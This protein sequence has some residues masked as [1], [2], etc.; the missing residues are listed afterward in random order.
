MGSRW[1]EIQNYPENQKGFTIGGH[2]DAELKNCSLTIS[3]PKGTIATVANSTI[4]MELSG[5]ETI[6]SKMVI[7]PG[8]H[9]RLAG[10]S[11]DDPFI[12]VWNRPDGGHFRGGVGSEILWD[13]HDPGLGGKEP[14]LFAVLK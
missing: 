2:I 1:Y 13:S 3:G 9:I 6:D 14:I 12:E 10:S 8:E 11:K 4:G 7:P 5:I